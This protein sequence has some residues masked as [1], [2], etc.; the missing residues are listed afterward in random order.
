MTEIN[1]AWNETEDE[2]NAMAD[3]QM[4][5]LSLS[6]VLVRPGWSA[7]AEPSRLD[8]L[9]AAERFAEQPMLHP[10]AVAQ[11]GDAWVLVSGRLRL[12]VW[13]HLG[14]ER[15]LFRWVEGSDEALLLLNFAENVARR[16]LKPNELVERIVLLRTAGISAKAIAKHSGYSVRWVRQLAAIRRD[17]HPELWVQFVREAPHLSIRAMLDLVAHPPEEQLERWLEAQKHWARGD[18]A[19]RGFS[20]IEEGDDTLSA[21][22]TARR[23]FP[24]RREVKK[25]LAAVMAEEAIEQEYRK[26]VADAL[27][28][29][30]FDTDLGTRFS[31]TTL[32]GLDRRGAKVIPI[33]P[34]THLDDEV[35]E[36]EGLVDERMAASDGEP[37][38][39][40]AER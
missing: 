34:D 24:R 31:W 30:L 35:P 28:W 2:P 21:G 20:E 40:G 11:R 22:A 32:R 1:E 12:E 33:R 25:L 3:M 37:A 6:E 29:M 26:G 7:R 19:A 15:G 18:T 9:D 14:H 38:R 17:A 36:G 4:V 27:R 5:E 16:A 13:R 23:R 8:V 10:P 39:G